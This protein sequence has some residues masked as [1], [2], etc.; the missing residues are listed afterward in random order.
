[1]R[2]PARLTAAS[3]IAIF[4]IMAGSLAPASAASTT[5]P[6]AADSFVLSTSPN[7]NRGAALTLKVR[8]DIK[9]S[10][11]RFDVPALSAGETI[12]A[13]TLRVFATTTSRCTIGVEVLRAAN[14][15]WGEKTIKWSNQPGPT[16]PVL[17]TG[18][19]T[20]KTGYKDFDVTSA[21][22]GGAPVSFLIRH[23]VG[24]NVTSD[25]SFTSREA[26]SNRPQLAVETTSGPAPACSDGTDNDADGVTDYPADPGC[27]SAA[28]T[29]ETDPPPAACDDGI[30]NDQDGSTDYP[31]DP[32][33]TSAADTDEADPRSGHLIAAAGDIACDPTMSTFDGSSPSTCQHRATAALLTG[34]E[35]VL[36]LGDLQYED[37]TLNQFNA[38]YDPSW[39]PFAP[40]TYPAVGNHEYHVAGAQGYF[41]YW[42]SK[43]RPTGG[44]GAGYYSYDIG[45]W[46]LIALNSNCSPV[47]C[48]EGT[49]QNDFL[50]QDLANT[51]KACILAYWHHPLFNAG[52][53]TMLAGPRAFWDDL[54]PAGADIVLNGHLHNYQRFGK[55]DPAGQAASN[56]IREF[57]VGT[58]G[59]SNGGSLSPSYPNFQ[60]G[61]TSTF[62][63][64]KLQLDANS[65]SWEYVTI[66]GTVLD[67]GGPVSCN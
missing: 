61:N 51:T 47:K 26:T 7:S 53:T 55:Q 12:S 38:S 44:V 29:D 32:G 56:G 23:A 22:T 13:A 16:G 43:G 67:S 21:V 41:D 25:V 58:G 64:L 66:N 24:C 62:G 3:V 50:E 63:V 42:A 54:Y 36:P 57:I 48:T 37:G 65:Y 31:A 35:A 52:S 17:A 60:F 39:G 2:R 14:D 33:C 5:V 15:T 34:A 6:A 18:Q 40:T 20:T 27:T 10:Y 19:W 49:V 9:I 59:R 4:A 46:H 8:N 1:M 28:D 11:I 30:D 45:T